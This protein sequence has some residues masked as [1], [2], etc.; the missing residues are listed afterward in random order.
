MMYYYDIK[1]YVIYLL[2]VVLCTYIY[3]TVFVEYVHDDY[4]F[5]SEFIF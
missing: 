4:L 2:V 3:I 5:R 1:Y